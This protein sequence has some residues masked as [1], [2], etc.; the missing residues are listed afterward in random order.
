MPGLSD[1][2]DKLT[3]RYL[4]P[5]Y[6]YLHEDDA[7]ARRRTRRA[8]EDLCRAQWADTKPGNRGRAPA[9]ACLSKEPTRGRVQVPTSPGRPRAGV[10][11]DDNAGLLEL[12]DGSR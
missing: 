5:K 7:A 2:R 10:N 4:P 3:S 1:V 11:L 9:N 12:M 8:S 6:A